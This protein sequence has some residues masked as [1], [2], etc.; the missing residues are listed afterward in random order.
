MSRR[1]E[2]KKGRRGEGEKAGKGEGFISSLFAVLFASLRLCGLILI[3]CFVVFAQNIYENRVIS[4]VSI[5][6]EIASPDPSATEQFRMIARDALGERY[7]LVRVRRALQALYDTKRIASVRVEATTVG[8]DRVNLRFIIRRVTQVGRVNVNVTPVP[9]G[10]NITEEQ[11]LYRLNLVTPGTAVTEQVLQSNATLILEYLRERGFFNAEVTYTQR[12][13]ESANEVAVT[14]NVNPNAQATVESFNIN[15]QGFNPAEINR[16]LALKPGAGFTR[17]RLQEDIDRIRNALR[18]ENRLAPN[19]GEPR[20]TF[21]EQNNTVSIGLE[22]EVGANVSVSVEAGDFKVSRSRQRELLPVIREGTLDYSAIIEGERR[23]ENYFQEQGYFFADVEAI[24]AVQPRF[25]ENEAI[26]TENET[27]VLCSALSGA[28]LGKREVEIVYQANLSRRLKLVDIRIE[29]T[30]ELSS[31]D[32][33]PILKSQV[34]SAL[35]IIPYL[36]YGRGYTSARLLDQDRNTIRTLMRELGYRNADVTVRQGVDPNGE[37]LIITFVVTEGIPTQ[38]QDVEIVGNQAFPDATLMTELPDLI[39]KNY[40]R[41]RAR[42]GSRELSTFY[43][44]EGFYDARVNFS[45]VELDEPPDVA[46]T[47][48]HVKLIYTVENEGEKVFINRVLING[49]DDTKSDAILRTITL[50]PGE[51]L[52]QR[53]IFSSEQNLYATDAFRRV[54]IRVE[55]AG[56]RPGGGRLTDVIIN[57][58]EQPPRL[59][60]YGGGY[61]TDIGAFGSFD[62]RHF[63]LFGK[64]QQGGL[65]IRAS[66][67]Q[68]FAQIDYISPRFLNDGKDP[69]G[70]IRYSPLTFTAQYQRDST[71]T[72]FFRSAFDR[73]TFGIVQRL[74]E[75]GNPIDEFGRETADPTLHRLTLSAETSRTL[76]NKNRTI[77]FLRYRFEDVRL[78]N[79]ESLLIRDLLRPDSRIRTSGFG[80]SLVRDTRENCHIKYTL[81]E[82]IQRGEPGEPCRYSPSDPTTG[83]YLTAEYNVS[84]PFLGANIG[85]HKFQGSYNRYYTIEQLKNTTFAGRVI[86]GLASVFSERERFSSTQFPDL[87]GLLPISERFFAGGSTTLRGFE[88][89]SAGPRV[90]IVPQGIFRNSEGEPITPPPFTVPFGGNAL[91]VV[92]LEARI[93]LTESIRAVPFYDGGNVFRRVGDIF[94]PP[95]VP[96][97]DVFRRNLRALWTNTVG[98]GFRIKTPVGGEFAI[99]YG[100]L[101]NPPEFLIPQ[102]T[103]PNAIYRLRQ[104]Q[105]HFRF[106]QAF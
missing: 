104:G 34:A 33:R 103:G 35:G 18:E 93:P 91:A 66:R 55:P 88:F 11:L 73:G 40:S 59:M 37:D 58:D 70:S 86:L 106:A 81:I 98:L 16:K 84:A 44:Q 22:G 101:L 64:L 96:D 10:E 67:L 72:R 78:Y 62:I 43:A 4:D 47:V 77:A 65:R 32:V 29:G 71:V 87:N 51:V 5:S 90:V 69:Q 105:L 2:E 28:E 48:E 31:E 68:Q 25:A 30:D 63:N 3:L 95:D 80:L 21:N 36:G 7:S 57:V 56:N 20:V 13:L 39:G 100:Y 24:C 50:R 17:Q 75:E 89:E 45:I 38:I 83:D 54:E 46:G 1:E 76:S 82:I 92:N 74:D 53:D 8:E 6:F 61:S 15:I 97:T 42:N 41:A 9:S 85:Y 102:Q 94:N 99:D 27:P 49:N 60:T 19:L 12:P 26:Y 23:L 14:F 79:I 52:R